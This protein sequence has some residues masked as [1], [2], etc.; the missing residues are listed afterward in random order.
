MSG[1]DFSALQELYAIMS[2]RLGAS[3]DDSYTAQLLAR[4]ASEV[5]RKFGEESTELII[6]ATKGD[7]QAMVSESADVLYHLLALWLKCG[8]TP[9]EIMVELRKRRS[10]SGL[11]EKANR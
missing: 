10:Q 8:I 1:S 11:E 9:E 7:K 3:V 4:D 6:E 5:A 2:E